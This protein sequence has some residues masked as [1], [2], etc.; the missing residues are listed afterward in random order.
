MLDVHPPHTPTHTWRDFLIHIATIV[1]GLLIAIGLEQSV[2]AIHHRHQAHHARELIVHE[3]QLNRQRNMSI[4]SSLQN[5]RA[6]L[7]DDLA[8]LD[9]LRAHQL[10]PA[11][12]LRYL[13]VSTNF[14]DSA[15]TSAHASGA[16]EYLSYESLNQW[17]NIYQ[18]LASLNAMALES[19]NNLTRAISTLNSSAGPI[20]PTPAELRAEIEQYDGDDSS[21]QRVKLEGVQQSDLLRLTPAKIDQLEA[22]LQ[23][24][25][26][27]DDQMMRFSVALDV[28]FD[29][30]PRQDK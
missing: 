26:S 1:V 12:R 15:W 10:Q 24:A 17:Q 9:H 28:T 20:Q 3:I 29:R 6:W 25:I 22:G 19:K 27:Q 21:T 2:E 16:A 4:I 18:F 14:S 7:R 30:L 8:V 13:R 11:D 5:H 23:L